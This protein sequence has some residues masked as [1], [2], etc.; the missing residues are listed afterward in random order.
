MYYAIKTLDGYTFTL[1][2]TE[3]YCIDMV[4]GENADIGWANESEL[5]AWVAENIEN[6]SEFIRA[7]ADSDGNMTIAR[8]AN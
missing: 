7:R 6:I 2:A 4:H 8:D 5:L 3:N 1:A